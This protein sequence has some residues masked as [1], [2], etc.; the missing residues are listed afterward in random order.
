MPREAQTGLGKKW[1][2]IAT[3]P[4]VGIQGAPR[5]LGPAGQIGSNSAATVVPRTAPAPTL[6][7]QA[8]PPSSQV[9]LQAGVCVDNWPF[10]LMELSL[11]LESRG[12]HVHSHGI[13]VTPE[14]ARALG[15]ADSPPALV[16]TVWDFGKG[17]VCHHSDLSLENSR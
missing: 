10:C 15:A 13:S 8:L 4:V 2:Q 11:K 17:L 16:P 1:Q 9:P 12:T 6:A 7:A 5:S 14:L 3:A